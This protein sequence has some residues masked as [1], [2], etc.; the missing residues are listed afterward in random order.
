MAE[1][2]TRVDVG[3]VATLTLNRPDALNALSPNLFEELRGHVDDLGGHG[4]SVGVVVLT[5]AGRSFSAGNDLKAIGRG[6]RAPSPYF[7]AETID[8]I[9]DLPQVVIVS[10]RGHCYTGALELALGGD[11]LVCSE[12]AKFADT[13]GKWSMTPTWGM[14]RRLPDRVGPLRAREMM[15]TGRVV[16]GAEAVEIGLANRC[17][18]DDELDV[19][20]ADLAAEIAENSWHTLR[21][22]KVLL[23]GNR[24]MGDREAVVWERHNSPGPGPDMAER[25]Q[26]F[27]R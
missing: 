11:L 17:V 19:A 5:G 9:E 26:S 7:Q 6:E 8:A 22:E 13:H 18:P 24:G 23:A 27:G 10:V 3:G 25:L 12:T 21:S 14:T 1:L 2:V 4:E 20:V 15:F 16:T